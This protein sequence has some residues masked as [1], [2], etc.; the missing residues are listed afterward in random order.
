MN[1]ELYI[2][3][4]I[5]GSKNSYSTT[6]AITRI[7]QIGIAAGICVMLLSIFITSG[8]KA[9]IIE[10][11]SGI[12]TPVTIHHTA[13]AQG[14]STKGKALPQNVI[15]KL[16]ANES[17]QNIFPSITKGA[18]L[19][20]ETELNGV[21]ITGLDSTAPL[22]FYQSK[23]IEGALPNFNTTQPSSQIVISRTIAQRLNVA[24]G[25]RLN[26]YFIQEPPR[27]RP[28]TVCGI[29]QTNIAEIDESLAICDLRTLQR[30]NNWDSIQYDTYNITFNSGV[31]AIDYA[32]ELDFITDNGISG[33]GWYISTIEDK[34]PEIL[35]WLELL[36]MNV[37]VILILLS[38]VA[39]FN[40]VS[41]LLILILERTTFVGI[42]KS[43][44]MT[45]VDMRRVFLWISAG[46]IGRGMLW[47]NIVALIIATI[48]H[49]LHIIK[50]DATVYYMNY[51][52]IN[53]EFDSL[54]LLNIGVL[55]VTLFMMIVPTMIISKIE[56][57]KVIRFE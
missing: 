6:G 38:F 40:M 48:Q 21:I 10:T 32:Y 41:S 49:Y 25:D 45:N 34:Q 12:S 27:V 55:A 42:M 17:I 36:D 11:L 51:V 18:I 4:R 37:W 39:G 46:L 30:V 2:A 14:Q 24:V 23:I 33:N 22:N 29:I 56:P 20:K 52:P 47:G 9:Q 54:I 50:L 53:I 5:L 26:A 31:N 1:I 13:I 8:F 35:D 19:K 43:V 28:L 57:I 15:D 44:G 16:R 3:R 7:A